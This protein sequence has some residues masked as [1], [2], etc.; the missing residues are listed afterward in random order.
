MINTEILILGFDTGGGNG[1][2]LLGWDWIHPVEN[3]NL[4][5]LMQ[6]G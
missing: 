4:I 3:A 1:Q 6:G 5:L 2:L